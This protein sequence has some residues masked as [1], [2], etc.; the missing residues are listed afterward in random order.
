MTSALIAMMKEP[1]LSERGLALPN[2]KGSSDLDARCM[3]IRTRQVEE[4][5]RRVL[6]GG[7]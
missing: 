4:G 1:L 7:I 5:R 3:G 6:E 2:R